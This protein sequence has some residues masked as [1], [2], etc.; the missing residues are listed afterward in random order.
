MVFPMGLTKPSGS[1][2]TVSCSQTRDKIGRWVS[3]NAWR[4]EM[5]QSKNRANHMIIYI[6]MSIW[7][8]LVMVVSIAILFGG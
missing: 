2:S 8:V 5:D 6:V 1:T 3:L 7:F 4:I